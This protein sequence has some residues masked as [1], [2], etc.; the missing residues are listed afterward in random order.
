MDYLNV[1]AA[2]FGAGS[3]AYQDALADPSS[4]NYHYYRG[5]DLDAQNANILTRYKNFN[6]PQGNS[7]I[8]DNNSQFSSAATLYPD[9]EDI[10]RDN[11]MNETEEYFQ[12]TVDLKPPT[13]P[14]MTIGQNFI[15]DK[16]VVNVSLADGTSRPET[17]YQLRIPIES[18]N[19][20]IGNIPDFKSIRF[21]RMFLTGFT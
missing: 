20:K 1:L 5:S 21:I 15:V 10:N 16:K 2:N 9:Q 19:N 14:E 7:P 4:D 13:D 11:T 3:K 12:Y 6:N 18:Y 17:W 8:A